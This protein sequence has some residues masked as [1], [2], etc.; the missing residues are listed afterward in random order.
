MTGLWKDG[1]DEGGLAWDD[2]NNNRAFLSQTISATLNGAS[3]YIESLRKPDQYKTEKGEPLNKDILHAPLP[4]G[5][6]GQFGF[7][8]LQSNMLMKYSKNQDAAK[9][10]LKWLHAEANYRK[11]FESQKGFATPCTAKW[12]SDKLWDVDP[13]MTPYK[14]AAKLG[15]A[16]GFAGPPDAKAQEGLSKYIITDMYAKAVQ[17]M[18]AE[19]SVKWAEAEL[20]K[21]Y[22][23]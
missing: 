23:A 15:Q 2:T 19:E 3:I 14:V 8:L 16:P 12:E 21:I 18:P 22:V 6:A 5:P 20:K 11:F 10:F 17:G 4:K 1:M 9:E 13:V 7:H